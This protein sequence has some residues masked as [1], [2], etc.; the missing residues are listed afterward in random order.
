[1]IPL[2]NI[3]ELNDNE[4][5]FQCEYCGNVFTTTKDQVKKALNNHPRIKIKY[6]SI[7]C[8]RKSK[9]KTILINC[10]ECDNQFKKQQHRITKNNFCSQSCGVTYNNKHK[11]TG[12]R[13]SKL[14]QYIEKHLI[15][16]YPDLKILFNNKGTIN[17]ELD[18][19]IPL[20]NLAFELNGIFHYEPIYGQ[21]KLNQ[22]QNNDNRKFQAC[23]EREIELCVID[24]S[25]QKYFKEQSSKKF[26][27]IIT[28]II[29][30]K[31]VVTDGVRSHD[32]L[33]HNQ[34]L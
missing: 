17:S 29:N 11:I 27:S 30:N 10:T 4:F 9:D 33:N 26:I 6:C 18:V 5:P 7:K 2:F 25:Q 19:Y 23:I 31:I 22:I 14:E 20:L 16:I 28:N 24:T 12:Y 34:T 3:N 21:D 1:M 15:L 32:L 13:R 8:S